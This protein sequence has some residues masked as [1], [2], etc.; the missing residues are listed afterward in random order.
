M[1]N[2]EL[3]ACVASDI[4]LNSRRFLDSLMTSLEV[5]K[6]CIGLSRNTRV[7]GQIIRRLSNLGIDE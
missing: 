1:T 3:N 5:Y 6:F 4:S 7:T 2:K